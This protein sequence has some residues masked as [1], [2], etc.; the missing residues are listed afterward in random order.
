VKDFVLAGP[1]DFAKRRES[2]SEPVETC[3][4]FRYYFG[5]NGDERARLLDNRRDQQ[6]KETN[7][8]HERSDDRKEKSQSVRHPAASH[9]NVANSAKIK[10]KDY[11]NEEEKKN[12]RSASHHPQDQDGENYRGEGRR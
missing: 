6:C 11:C 5:E 2:P 7:D 12:A 10:R 3:L 4:P 8:R 1:P 9:E